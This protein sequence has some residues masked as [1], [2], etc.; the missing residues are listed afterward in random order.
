ME[1]AMVG[2]MSIELKVLA[3]SVLLGFAQI[4]F[5]ASAVTKLRGLQWNAGARDEV[6]PPPHGTA[7]R[8]DRALQNFK[9]TFPL[10]L[11]AVLLVQLTGR[12]SSLSAAGAEIY[13]LARV[14]YIPLYVM[15]TRYIRTVVW[16]ASIVG[17]AMVLLSLV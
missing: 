13:F 3:L 15:G 12:Q 8:W 6:M 11:A 7:G 17:I 9:E 4:I 1:T 5:A 14:I 10:F 2:E 16:I